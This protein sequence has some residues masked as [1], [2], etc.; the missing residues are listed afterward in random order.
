MINKKELIIGSRAS[1]LALWQA[2]HIAASLMSAHPGLRVKIIKIK[3][4]GDKILDVP[5]AKVGGKGLFVKELEEALLERRVDLAV[6]SMKDMPTEL[7][8]GLAITAI[9]ER[10]DARDALIAA[11]AKSLEEL[12]DGATIGTSSL[13]R[14][15]QLLNYNPSF[16]IA[17]LRGNLGTRLRKLKEQDLDAIILA[18]AGVHRLGFKE[19]IS[20][21]LPVDLSLPAVGQGTLGIES[22]VD[23]NEVNDLLVCLNHASSALAVMAERAF[24]TRLEGGCQVPIGAYAR[25]VDAQGDNYPEEKL[26]PL[27]EKGLSVDPRERSENVFSGQTSAERPK[28]VLRGMIATVEGKTVLRDQIEGE[29][30]DTRRMGVDLAEKM[31]S[32]GG[33][34]I[35]SRIY[36]CAV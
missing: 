26:S 12:P 18:A 13:R 25:V 4:Q 17:Q 5:L 8:E 30:A 27:F 15:S 7:P 28:V 22:R 2:E 33:E 36:G 29:I 23:D 16:K 19:R 11:S 10:E 3:T 1:Q 9:T 35:L 34:D 24:L 31:L 21:Y 20:Q 14:Q 6:H 32:L